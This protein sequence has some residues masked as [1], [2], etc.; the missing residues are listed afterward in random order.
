MIEANQNIRAD[1][2]LRAFASVAAGFCI[3]LGCSVIIGWYGQN[4]ALVRVF[5]GVTAM[6]PNTAVAFVL[7]GA[8]ILAGQRG[9]RR[10]MAVLGATAGVFGLLTAIEH[11][12]AF[13]LRINQLLAERRAGELASDLTQMAPFSGISFSLAGGAL[14]IGCDAERSR[15]RAASMGFLGAAIFGV[16]TIAFSAYLT[17]LTGAYAWRSFNGMA[18]HTALGF[19]ILGAGIVAS[20]WVA[21]IEATTDS[22]RWLPLLVGATGL[23]ATIILWQAFHASEQLK[24]EQVVRNEA[25]NVHNQI[26]SN[27]NSTLFEVLRGASRWQRLHLESENETESEAML[28]IQAIRGLR[29]I[30]W[31]DLDNRLRWV[32]PKEE[33]ADLIGADLS[34]DPRHKSAMETVRLEG[35]ALTAADTGETDK[36]SY[37]IYAPI[38]DKGGPRGFLV[39]TFRAQEMLNDLIEDESYIGYSIAVYD[40]NQEIFRRRRSDPR[41]QNWMQQSPASFGRVTWTVRVWPKPV[42]MVGLQSSAGLIALVIGIF[43]TVLFAAVTYFAQTARLRALALDVSN[44]Q[45]E[46][47]IT[48]RKHAH[49]QL[50]L[51]LKRISA[52]REINL[53]VT[54]TL[55]LRSVLSVLVETIQRLLPYGGLLVWLTDQETGELKRTACWNLD[56]KEWLGRKLIGIPELVRTAM[57]Q[58]TP[59]VVAD[60]Q[61]DPR[62]LDR[63]F[64]RRNGLISYLGVPLV[65][66]AETLGVLVFLTRE[67]H[68][69]NDDEVGFLSSLASQAAVAIQNSQL[70]EKIQRQAVELD[71][72]NKSHADFTAMI[73][74]DLRSPLSNIIGITEMMHQG[75]F[76][77]TSDEQ[78]EWLDRMRKNATSL[79]GLVTDF[80][81]LSKLES[82]RVELARAATNVFELACT[83]VENYRPLAASKNITLSCEGDPMMPA[84]DADA[85]RLDQVLTNLVTNALKFTPEGGKITVAI[86]HEASAMRVSVKDTGVGIAGDEIPNLFQKYR[87]ATSALTSEHKGTGLGLLICKMIVEA[88]GGKIWVE[89]DAGQGATFSFTLPMG[90]IPERRPN[91]DIGSTLESTTIEVAR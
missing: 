9:G 11:M 88:H 63:E 19:M 61:N 42:T 13:D 41:Y 85:R 29:A 60:I 5:E 23:M 16:G 62:T 71:K 7:C 26:A 6:Q 58:K 52:L 37:F 81:D 77:A 54:S 33:Y 83:T 15:L 20:G 22:A 73:A 3:L 48:E 66:K 67:A 65:T 44:R 27:V 91:G 70:Y 74:H 10:F 84:I 8:A 50:Q 55:D 51:Q 86:T 69:F 36:G 25:I 78:N 56:E 38:S 40:G 30:G 75:L 57:E 87:Q 90:A 45:L 1:D 2:Y 17:G 79:V 12:L 31:V 76:G 4:T 64:Y 43:S 14:V 80:L 21:A 82:G 39:A 49:Q 28:L 32:V 68:E 59:V 72:V 18:L 34:L 47:E 35:M 89:S 46:R 53:A 24:I